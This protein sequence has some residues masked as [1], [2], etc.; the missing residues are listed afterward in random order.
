MPQ[1]QSLKIREDA[2]FEYELTLDF[3]DEA[4][5][6]DRFSM[7]V[8]ARKYALGDGP[9]HREHLGTIEANVSIRPMEGVAVVEIEKREYRV[10]L[11]KI[12]P[13]PPEA[14]GDE[15]GYLR[16]VME[17]LGDRLETIAFIIEKA[18]ENCPSPDPFLG[19]MI[20]GGLSAGIGQAIECYNDLIKAERREA[21]DTA[22]DAAW[23]ERRR[24]P[25]RARPSVRK[26]FRCMR[27]N[28]LRILGKAA[29]RA[30]RCA[31]SLGIF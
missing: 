16:E 27:S 22:E 14:F 9:E 26:M 1:I 25:H 10:D 21:L 2:D 23:W 8:S 6:E 20:K 31:L 12:A 5:M 7:V 17:P 19:C 29:T 11:A 30:G 15:T 24:L 13:P 4:I 18:V 3:D 28:G